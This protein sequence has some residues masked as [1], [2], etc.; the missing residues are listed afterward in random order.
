MKLIDGKYYPENA[1]QF[2]V[3]SHNYYRYPLS[4]LAEVCR[5]GPSVVVFVGIERDED[6]EEVF[7]HEQCNANALILA[8]FDMADYRTLMDAIAREEA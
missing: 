8:N 2:A 5:E 1:I 6:G 7:N 3:L 4:S